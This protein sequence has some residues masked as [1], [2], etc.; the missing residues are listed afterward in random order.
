MQVFPASLIDTL[1]TV[2]IVSHYI[3]AAIHQDLTND[4]SHW[5]VK[6]VAYGRCLASLELKLSLTSTFSHRLRTEL[7][8]QAALDCHDLYHF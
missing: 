4:N 3:E 2:S 8:Q 1:A 6:A 5:W 7:R